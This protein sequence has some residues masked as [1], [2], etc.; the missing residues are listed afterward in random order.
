MKA[1]I[2]D[3]DQSFS[4]DSRQ[5]TNFLVLKLPSGKKIRLPIDEDLI[6]VV[7]A[8]STV[9]SNEVPEARDERVDAGSSDAVFQHESFEEPNPFTSGEWQ[10]AEEQ[11]EEEEPL[12]SPDQHDVV[13]WEA[14]PDSELS[15]KIKQILKTSRINRIITVSELT[16]LKLQIEEHL[17]RAPKAGKVQW[18]QGPTVAKERPIR[19]VPM[20]IAGNPLPP[21]GIVEADMTQDDDDGVSQV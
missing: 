21:G 8:E 12:N 13:D 2:T 6:D 4:L 16:A 9:P 14:L 18:G 1:T 5:M 11:V 10:A 17:S 7:I 19:T 15:P 20:D 3:I